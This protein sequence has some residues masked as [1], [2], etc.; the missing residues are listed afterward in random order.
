MVDAQDD[1]REDAN[2]AGGKYKLSGKGAAVNAQ[3]HTL[4]EHVMEMVED[5]ELLINQE[6]DYL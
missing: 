2:V 3:A 6:L 4:P 1:V 5:T